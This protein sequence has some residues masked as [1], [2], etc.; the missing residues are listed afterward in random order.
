MCYSGDISPRY[1]AHSFIS[2][3]TK[4]MSCFKQ[5]YISQRMEIDKKNEQVWKTARLVI[6]RSL[7]DNWNLII[8]YHCDKSLIKD[9]VNDVIFQSYGTLLHCCCIYL[10]LRPTNNKVSNELNVGTQKSQN[11]ISHIHLVKIT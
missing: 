8:F 2:R 5:V 10:R 4:N 1:S 11:L 7:L 9:K 6:L 3:E